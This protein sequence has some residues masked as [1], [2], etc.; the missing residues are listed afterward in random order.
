MKPLIKA[1]KILL[2]VVIGL[3]AVF[4][5]SILSW[6]QLVRLSVAHAS[7][8]KLDELPIR[9]VAL[10]LGTTSKLSNGLPNPYLYNRMDA[11]AEIYKAGKVETI[12]ISGQGG[13]YYSETRDMTNALIER[14]VPETSIKNDPYG[15]RTL[16][17][18]IRAH[19]V[20]QLSSFTIVSQRFHNHRALYIC[21]KRGIDATAYEANDVS[22]IGLWV[23]NIARE[24]LARVKMFEDLYFLDTQ[25]KSMELVQSPAATSVAK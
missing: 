16:D 5:I 6:Y 24:H 7:T 10:V 11:A 3:I 8:D 22:K 19:E 23:R 17:S 20:F 25:P 12:L 1:G 13:P 2:C 21:R 14:G 18:V 4:L 15:F 9:K